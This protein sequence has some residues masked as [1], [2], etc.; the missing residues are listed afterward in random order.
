[1]AEG[2]ER[3]EQLAVLAQY[4]PVGVQGYL[5]AHAVPAEEVVS[6]AQ[7]AAARARKFLAALE[8]QPRIMRA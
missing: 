6:D 3:T 1:M 4:G 2:V 7:D 5:L 8:M